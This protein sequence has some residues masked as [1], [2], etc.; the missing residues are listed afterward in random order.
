MPRWRVILYHHHTGICYPAPAGGQGWGELHSCMSTPLVRSIHSCMKTVPHP[1]IIRRNYCPHHT[2]TLVGDLSLTSL[3]HPSCSCPVDLIQLLQETH[4]VSLVV[5]SFSKRRI[6][7]PVFISRPVGG[8]PHVLYLYPARL[9]AIPMLTVG[10]HCRRCEALAVP[11]FVVKIYL[12]CGG[13]AWLD[14]SSS[15]KS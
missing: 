8:P 4:P 9:A 5:L 6:L 13:S 14:L 3:S 1:R 7:N 2:T 12:L 11:I 15:T 10:L